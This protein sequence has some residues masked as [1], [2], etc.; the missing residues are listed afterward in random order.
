MARPSTSTFAITSF[1]LTL[2]L[3]LSSSNT[4]QVLKTLQ[5]FSQ[6]LFLVSFFNLT[7]PVSGSLL[8]EGGC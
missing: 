8:V 3:G 6:N 2:N 4:L 5:I 7:S 1:A